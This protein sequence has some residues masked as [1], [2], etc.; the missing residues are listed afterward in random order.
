MAVSTST[1]AVPV[2]GGTMSAFLALPEGGRGR[3]IVMLQEIFGVNDA[4]KSKAR[5]FAE[6]GFVVLV[7]D[8]FWRLKPGIDLGYDDDGRQQAFGHMQAF[9]FKAG[10]GDIKAAFQA[11]AA[12]DDV[13]GMPAYVGYCLGGKLAVVAGAATADAAAVVA[14]YGVKLDENIEQ[15]G[16]MQCPV[17]LHFGTDDTH[18]PVEVSSNI[19]QALADSDHVAVHIYDG[20]QHGFA[21]PV[22]GNV[23]DPPA[24]ELAMTRTLD[25]LRSV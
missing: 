23:F 16:A 5:A 8:L 6:E 4:M 14:F 20:A 12:R 3:P 9:D 17:V 15:I 24:A 10:I 21:N 1:I 2:A 11:L 25:A 22:R 19:Q 7:P 18:I 13:Q